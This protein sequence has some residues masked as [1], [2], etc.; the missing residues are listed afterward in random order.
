MNPRLGD[1]NSPCM[2]DFE[3]SRRSLIYQMGVAEKKPP[4]VD[5]IKRIK[6]IDSL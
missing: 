4:T 3:D 1:Q 6:I 2:C 5:C